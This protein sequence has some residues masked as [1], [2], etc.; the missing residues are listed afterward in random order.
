[1]SI[2]DYYGETMGYERP[3]GYAQPPVPQRPVIPPPQPRPI[4]QQQPRPII[5]Q[6]QPQYFKS[7]YGAPQQRPGDFLD[8]QPKPSFLDAQPNPGFVG[9]MEEPENS[10]MMPTPKPPAAPPIEGGEI[11][12]SP[13]NQKPVEVTA[14]EEAEQL[15]K[16]GYDS[17]DQ[18]TIEKDAYT[19]ADPT[20]RIADK[21][22]AVANSVA[23]L[24]MLD[25]SSQNGLN[26]NNTSTLPKQDKELE[27][28]AQA[29]M[30]PNG[31]YRCPIT[32][33]PCSKET[34]WARFLN[35]MKSLMGLQDGA[36]TYKKAKALNDIDPVS[37]QAVVPTL[38]PSA[39][40]NYSQGM[41][42][43]ILDNKE[44]MR[45]HDETSGLA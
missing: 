22:G 7:P 5:P 3:K 2:G 26:E 36:T 30:L 19:L 41:Q 27:K 40:V 6:Q 8:A 1:M 11:F 29:Y 44:I 15:D 35:F 32:N 43:P 20:A 23:R 33:T 38:P 37:R 16:Q 45:P 4:V 14:R 25:K 34:F 17:F 28:K 12:N 42:A 9:G 13:Y 24:N 18:R 21:A 31:M 10:P 39:T